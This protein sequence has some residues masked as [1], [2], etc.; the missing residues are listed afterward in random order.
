MPAR[1]E[2]EAQEGRSENL[3]AQIAQRQARMEEIGREREDLEKTRETQ[4]AEVAEA[5]Q[6]G[7]V[8]GVSPTEFAP[9]EAKWIFRAWIVRTREK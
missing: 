9:E 6:L 4:A 8:N 3:G 5:A 7:L 1:Q 2:L